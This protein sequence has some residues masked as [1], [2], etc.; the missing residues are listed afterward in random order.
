MIQD[1]NHAAKKLRKAGELRFLQSPLSQIGAPPTSLD[2]SGAVDI[3]RD[4]QRKALRE[5]TLVIDVE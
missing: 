1:S 4:F 5:L 2:D 3:G